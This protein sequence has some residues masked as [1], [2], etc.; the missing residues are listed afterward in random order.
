MRK[1]LSKP[2]G[3]SS[4]HDDAG[5]TAARPLSASP[6]PLP[7]RPRP[8]REAAYQAGVPIASLDKGPDGRLAVLAGRHVLKTVRV[9]DFEIKETFDLRALITAQASPQAN[10]TVSIAEQLSIRDVKWGRGR[11]EA[12]IFTACLRGKIFLYDLSRLGMY[13]GGSGAGATVDFIHTQE[14]S[15]QINTLDINPHKEVYL[16]SGSQDG[17][18]RLFDTRKLLASRMGAS[19]KPN[20]SFKCNADVRHVQWSTRNGDYFA[21]CTEQGAVMKWDTRKPSAPVLRIAGHEKA[22]AAISWHPDGKHLISGGVDK[23]CHIWDMSETADKRQKPKWTIHTPASVAAVTWRPP[24]WSATC[25]GLR[26]AQ[27]AVSYDVTGP[28]RPGVNAVHL[29]DLARPTMPYKTMD[30]FEC[31]PSALL[32][33]DP[34]FLWTAGEDG[35]FRQN[36]LVSAPRILDRTAVS[37]LAFSACGDVLTFLDE[38]PPPVR[39]GAHRGLPSASAV[40]AATAAAAAAAAVSSSSYTS[41]PTTPTTGTSR[42]D[43]EDDVVRAFVMPRRRTARRKRRASSVHH[44]TSST[45]PADHPTVSSSNQILSLDDAL[46]ATGTYRPQQIMA[47]GHI[48]SATHKNTYGYMAKTYLEAL[49]AGLR[50]AVRDGTVVPLPQRVATILD[51]YASA[52]EYM[53]QFRLAQV[54]RIIAFAMDLLFHNREQYHRKRRLEDPRFTSLG[55]GVRSAGEMHPAA[56]SYIHVHQSGGTFESASVDSKDAEHDVGQQQSTRALAVRSLLAE[57]IESTSNMPTPLARPVSGLAYLGE[58]FQEGAP[59]YGDRQHGVD[60]NGLPSDLDSFSLPPAKYQEFL[61][62]QPPRRHLDSVPFSE[63][64]QDSEMSQN[65]SVEGYDFYDTETLAK[66]IDVPRAPRR[67]SVLPRADPEVSQG[68]RTSEQSARRAQFVRQD[69]TDSTG[70]IFEISQVSAHTVVDANDPDEDGLPT[71]VHDKLRQA[72]DRPSEPGDEA[73]TYESHRRTRG[74]Q[75]SRQS[76]KMMPSSI[77]SSRLLRLNKALL[78]M[79]CSGSDVASTMPGSTTRDNYYRTYSQDTESSS[80]SF[81]P[82]PLPPNRYATE[83]ATNSFTMKRLALQRSGSSRQETSSIATTAE[84]PLDRDVSSDLVADHDYLPWPH[85]PPFPSPVQSGKSSGLDRNAA[86]N[87]YAIVDRAVSFEARTSPLNASA[88]VLL[89]QPLMPSDFIDPLQA[90]AIL[91]QHHA[92][93]M[94]MKLFLEAALLRKLCVQ[95]WP[96]SIEL[97]KWGSNYPSV[98]APAKKNV[99]ASYICVECKKPRQAEHNSPSDTIESIWRCDRCKNVKAPCA[100]C[101]HRDVSACHVLD[102][103]STKDENSILSTW[104]YCFGCSHGGHLT[105]LEG[106]HSTSLQDGANGG[107][108]YSPQLGNLASEM[109]A[110]SGSMPDAGMGTEFSDGCCPLDGCGHACLPGHWRTET[111]TQR[112]EDLTPA[113]REATWTASK[114]SSLAADSPG[115]GSAIVTNVG[116]ATLGAVGHAGAAEGTGSTGRETIRADM[117]EVAPSRAVDMIRESLASARG[118]AGVRSVQGSSPGR[119]TVLGG[120]GEI[121]ERERRKSVKFAGTDDWS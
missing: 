79:E 30:R 35:L 3:P 57:E 116:L 67:I 32:W 2:G 91:R 108:S 115:D 80:N 111:I 77:G 62:R 74:R 64:S 90:T 40:A 109:A 94:G 17:M 26:A 76:E 78:S 46:H 10:S 105:C 118:E 117:H 38:R 31:S 49:E 84:L 103:G 13:V 23:A 56:S 96:G 83:P 86:L 54:W 9:D 51:I 45:P 69:S 113:I 37:T 1:L 120:G 60:S 101:G 110:S 24:Q 42:S 53:S 14:D 48:P 99:S 82:A 19:F 61:A 7:Y 102:D 63:I 16:L 21:C 75:W 11:N 73:Q 106:W 36:D 121:R 22:C 114:A 6:V 33:R 12:L 4:P 43:S 81:S 112:S 15:R 93:L 95:G 71:A 20:I 44:H 87:P 100:V 119:G 85:D 97:S 92:R 29:W 107:V 70:R 68:S 41:E 89:L 50:T 27:V 104:W 34:E 66:A 8:P 65:S 58:H 47:I 28:K 55:P 25:Q 39:P 52:A 88:M 59:K 98:T 5:S 72:R 18:V